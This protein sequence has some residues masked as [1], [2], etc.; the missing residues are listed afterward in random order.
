MT[1]P[2]IQRLVAFRDFDRYYTNINE[3]LLFYNIYV[4]CLSIWNLDF[5]QISLY[6]F[7]PASRCLNTANTFFGLHHSRLPSCPHHPH[8]HTSQT[9]LPQLHTCGVAVQAL[10]RMICSLS[11][12]VEH[13]KLTRGCLCNFLPPLLR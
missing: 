3:T 11:K 9:P 8:L 7:L 6:S 13:S 4:D 2:P 1:S 12:A 10:H 5:F